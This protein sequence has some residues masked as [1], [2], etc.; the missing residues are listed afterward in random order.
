MQ[1]LPYRLSILLLLSIQILALLRSYNYPAF[2]RA[3]L[4][5]VLNSE[6]FFNALFLVLLSL[7]KVY[8]L[9][10]FMPVAM[11]VVS[12]VCEFEFQEKIL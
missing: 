3:Y 10:Y 1:V 5:T 8:S 9:L 7:V 2:S 12:G 6:F 4:S 11:H